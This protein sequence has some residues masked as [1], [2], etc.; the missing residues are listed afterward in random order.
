MKTVSMSGSLRESV[1]KKDAKKHRREGRVPCV[2]YGGKEEIHFVLEEKELVKLLFTPETFFIKLD[3]N[4]KEYN[5]IIKDVQYHPVSDHVLHADFLEFTEGKPITVAIPVKL[6]GNA[7]GVIKGGRLIKKH[8]KL[9]ATGLP[10]LM[11]EYIEVDISKLDINDKVLIG[12]I[13]VKDI[14]IKENPEQ[15]L[16]KVSTTRMAASMAPGEAEGEEGEEGAEGETAEGE[17][18][19]GEA[20]ETANE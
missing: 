4:G 15:F 14:N 12:D 1:G 13:K 6:V 8:R 10:K 2:L 5:C 18:P 3:I 11:P 16:V 9:T 7:P 20:S 19:A 17:A